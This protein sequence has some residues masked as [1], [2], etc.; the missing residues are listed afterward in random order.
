[1]LV[2]QQAAQFQQGRVRLVFHQLPQAPLAS[3]IDRR[4]WA[5]TTL[6]GRDHPSGATLAQQLVHEP[7][8][9]AEAVGHFLSGFG[10]LIACRTNPLTK[11]QRVGLHAA[12]PTDF[13]LPYRRCVQ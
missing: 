5:S 8:A 12:P 9:H 11:I 4:G 7:T 2:V 13:K 10:S 1:L 3:R 6:P